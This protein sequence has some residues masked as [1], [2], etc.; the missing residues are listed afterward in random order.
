MSSLTKVD[1]QWQELITKNQHSKL[2]LKLV[3]SGGSCGNAEL[4]LGGT[5][6]NIESFSFCSRLFPRKTQYVHGPAGSSIVCLSCR[7]AMV[8]RKG[9]LQRGLSVPVALVFVISII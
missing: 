4:L 9:G 2:F 6:E 5:S 7:T 8:C 3:P 1:S